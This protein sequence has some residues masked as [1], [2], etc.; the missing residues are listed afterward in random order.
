MEF[1]VKK[2]K[3]W[4]FGVQFEADGK[5]WWLA[6]DQVRI[7]FRICSSGYRFK[8]FERN[9]LDTSSTFLVLNSL[10][11]YAIFLLALSIQWKSSFYWERSD[12]IRSWFIFLNEFNYHSDWTKILRASTTRWSMRE[13]QSEREWNWLKRSKAILYAWSLYLSCLSPC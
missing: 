12:F 2:K 6:A 10:N 3:V 8:R 5:I 13:N 7:F 4:Y 11:V 9:S 1:W